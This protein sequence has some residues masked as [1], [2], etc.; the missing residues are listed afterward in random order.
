[1]RLEEL[2]MSPGDAKDYGQLLAAVHTHIDSL[3][4]LLES[5]QNFSRVHKG[6]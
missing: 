3:H 6:D 2:D 4:H 5:A 1:M